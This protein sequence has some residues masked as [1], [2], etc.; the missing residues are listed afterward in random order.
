MDENEKLRTYEDLLRLWS[1]RINLVGPEAL[2]NLEAHC[3]EALEAAD[4][5]EPEGNVLDM[6]SGGGLPGIPIAIHCTEARVHLVEADE[7]KWA[8]LKAVIRECALNAVVLGDR[9]ERVVERLDPSLHFSL[10][11]SRAVGHHDRWLPV[12]RDRIPPGG[13][14]ALFEGRSAVPDVEGFATDRVHRLS[15]GDANFLVVLRRL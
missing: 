2:A 12:I 11:T 15:R 7:K 14:V 8:F 13:R 9:L 5:L 3:A 4:F 6:G 1:R 10:V